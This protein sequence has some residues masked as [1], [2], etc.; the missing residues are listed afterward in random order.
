MARKPSDWVRNTTW[1]KQVRELF[2]ERLSRCRGDSSK[3]QSIRI[4]AWHLAEN[5]L[6]ADAMSLLD[7]LISNFNEPTEMEI[8]HIQRA[9]SLEALQRPV[10][11][12]GALRS[13]SAAHRRQPNSHSYSALGF[14]DLVVRAGRVQDMPHALQGLDELDEE[15]SVMFPIHHYRL[16]GLRALLLSRLGNTPRA[17]AFARSALEHA[18]QTSSGMSKH[19]NLGLVEEND[20]HL[21]TIRRIATMPA[22]QDVLE[23][24]ALSRLP[25]DPEH[26][27]LVLSLRKPGFQLNT[28]EDWIRQPGPQSAEEKLVEALVTST[29]E[30]LTETLACVLS[31]PQY[32]SP[33]PALIERFREVQNNSVRWQ[34]GDAISRKRFLKKH[35]LELLELAG[36]SRFGTA[37]QMVVNRLHR[38]KLSQV[39][40]LLLS[41]L[42]DP[43][44]DGWAASALCYCGG[45]HSLEV[46]RDFRFD[47]GCTPLLKREVPKAISKIQA[48]LGQS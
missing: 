38:I 13:A 29:D 8:A 39:E 47:R 18:A 27:D 43:E 17:S 32:K 22:D 26:R 21:S 37:R 24:E 3:A 34:I 33:L 10:E 20:R 25:M 42:S 30:N 9:R 16:N 44:V 19:P 41:L 35:W 5:G 1:T 28:L 23:M 40:P 45:E 11:A 12:L 31:H 36:S 6:H 7:L 14:A 48:R 2:F 4:Q 46:L 15:G